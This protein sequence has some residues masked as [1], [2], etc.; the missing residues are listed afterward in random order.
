MLREIEEQRWADYPTCQKY[1]GLSHTTLWRLVKSG[2]IRSAKI[3][4]SV[5]IDLRS[6]EAFMEERAESVNEE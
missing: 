1:S 4:R 5:R 2:T 3:G 6:L